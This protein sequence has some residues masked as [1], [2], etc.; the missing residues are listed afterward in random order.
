MSA[1]LAYY[2]EIEERHKGALLAAELE[3]TRQVIQDA[4]KLCDKMCFDAGGRLSEA[5]PGLHNLSSHFESLSAM[6]N[7][8]EIATATEHLER[9]AADVEALGHG[10]TSEYGLLNDLISLNHL[11]SR[12]I[13]DLDDDVRFLGAMVSYVK[14]ELAAIDN[15]GQRLEGFSESLEELASTTKNTLDKFRDAHE[16]LLFQLRKTATAQ[17]SFLDLNQTKLVSVAREIDTSLDILSGRRKAISG[18]ALEI[19]TTAQNIGMRIGQSV[20]AL[21][22]GD[23]ARQR[24]EHVEEALSIA[25]DFSGGGDS[26]GLLAAFQG[27]ASDDDRYLVLARICNLQ[28]LQL[29][30]TAREFTPEISK[31]SSLLAQ[32]LDSVGG[33]GQR[34][35]DLFG[36][37]DHSSHSFLGD[38]EQK[39]E[40]A[41]QLIDQCEQSRAT[42]DETA[43]EV[44]STIVALERLAVKVAAMAID[45]TIIGTNA[46]VAA[47]RLGTRGAA[48][49][50]IAQHLRGHAIRIADGV[51]Q[52]KPALVGVLKAANDF[53]N[54]RKGQ[55]AA[56]MAIL[57]TGMNAALASFKSCASS[58]S[59]VRQRLGDE[60]AAATVFLKNAM[61]SL[62]KVQVV[63][64]ELE[65]AAG[66]ISRISTEVCDGCKSTDVLD[67]LLDALLRAKYT[68]ASERVLHD[69]FFSGVV[70]EVVAAPVDSDMDCLF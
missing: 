64:G 16:T 27:N 13:V 34:S 57:A 49:S 50:V 44:V 53:A 7:G 25:E 6:L 63:D 39:L 5:V 52:L 54:A 45:M 60:S 35:E 10:L 59:D 1:A 20:V 69:T 28:S 11:L 26:A 33:L 21:Q 38:L 66:T 22:I 24:I 18:I 41:H 31:I 55:D 61:A 12:H 9:V 23:S 65:E 14:I 70:R 56:S 67:T 40:A 2:E 19:G 37:Q 51:K 32:I 46:I 36:S 8:E 48:L 42:V 3:A 4:A 47:H 58:V 43:A 62:D 15:E 17:S 68:M 29:A 30:G